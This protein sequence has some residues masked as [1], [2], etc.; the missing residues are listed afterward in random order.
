MVEQSGVLKG[1]GTS[2]A[3][4]SVVLLF[5]ISSIAAVAEDPETVVRKTIESVKATVIAERERKAEEGLRGKLEEII[6]PV[7]DFSEM[8]KRSLGRNWSKGTQEQQDQYLKL[9]TDLLASNYLDKIKD[10][11]KSSI[12][13]TG[14]KVRKRKALVKTLVKTEEVEFPVFYRMYNAKEGWRVYDV[15]IENVSLVTNFRNEFSSIIRKEDFSGLLVR[16]QEK[17]EKRDNEEE[18]P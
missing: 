6:D 9:F 14:N 12:S 11:D 7:F 5:A 15:V 10:I 2:C 17:I 18:Q 3:L 4:I 16:L 8:A 1:I 13:F